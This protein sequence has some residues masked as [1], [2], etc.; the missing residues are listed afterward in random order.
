MGVSDACVAG[1]TF[2]RSL[3]RAEVVA[4]AAQSAVNAALDEISGHAVEICGR[5]QIE[6]HDD[7]WD[8]ESKT[9][10]CGVRVKIPTGPVEVDPMRED[11]DKLFR[12][13]T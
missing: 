12:R 2:P 9:Y 3:L 5:V 8:E 11:I 4:Y 7:V 6:F 10:L 13:A 1:A